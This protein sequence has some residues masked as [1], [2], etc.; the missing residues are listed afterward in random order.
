MNLTAPVIKCQIALT[1]SI[2]VLGCCLANAGATDYQA[3]LEKA[4]AGVA[5]VE[6][7]GDRSTLPIVILGDRHLDVPVSIQEAVFLTRL[8]V[9]GELA[10]IIVEGFL[11]NPP[12]NLPASRLSK[13]LHGIAA[14]PIARDFL[15]RGEINTAEYMWLS[16]GTPLLPGEDSSTYA[17]LP[18]VNCSIIVK[19]MLGNPLLSSDRSQDIKSLRASADATPDS[20]KEMVYYKSTLA[21]AKDLNISDRDRAILRG[22]YNFYD[23]R[24]RASDLLAHYAISA[25]QE[26][27]SGFTVILVGAAHTAEI[28]ELLRSS[29][30]SVASVK[31]AATGERAKFE[32]VHLESWPIRSA[33]KPVNSPVVGDFLA[34][35][36]P[37]RPQMNRMPPPVVTQPRFLPDVEVSA[38]TLQL[39]HLVL[40]AAGGV[41][42]PPPPIHPDGVSVASAPEPN[43]LHL[44]PAILVGEYWKIA[45]YR[46]DNWKGKTYL[47]FVICNTDD[48]DCKRPI[49]AKAT[50]VDR[51]SSRETA[52]EGLTT[53]LSWTPKMRQLAK[54]EPCP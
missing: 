22:C 43:P 5:A 37:N 12:Q 15:L 28:S 51:V 31:P 16:Y 13:A 40:P 19:R 29:N 36:F 42:P 23:A 4:S 2:A 20:R 25:A 18:S 46:W 33:G 14:E 34:N 21:A 30:L 27:R 1:A 47:Y 32:F 49:Y 6:F 24:H 10:Q 53:D 52:E 3:L 39:A 11:S 26:K 35:K 44:A 38:M 17:D 50:R 8:Q 45:S 41:G 54:V 9:A 48:S 7:K